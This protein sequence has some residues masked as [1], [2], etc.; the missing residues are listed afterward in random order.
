MM[1]SSVYKP[2]A[3]TSLDLPHTIENGTIKRDCEYK[4]F[5]TVSLLTAIDLLTG[6]AIPLV[7]NTHKSEDFFVFLKILNERNP[8]ADII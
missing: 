2:F 5:G 6:E 1:K 4:W 7:R 8:K 3:P